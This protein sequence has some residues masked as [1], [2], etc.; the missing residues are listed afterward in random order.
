M[1]PAG[2]IQ[3]IFFDSTSNIQFVIDNIDLKIHDF[4][5]NVLTG[6]PSHY[7][8][9][10]N[11][12]KSNGVYWTLWDLI[13]ADEIHAPLVNCRSTCECEDQSSFTVSLQQ[14]ICQLYQYKSNCIEYLKFE[15]LI[16]NDAELNKLK[17]VT[18]PRIIYDVRSDEVWVFNCGEWMIDPCKSVCLLEKNKIYF[19]VSTRKLFYIACDCSVYCLMDLPFNEDPC[20][21]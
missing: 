19:N 11:Y 7:N 3:Q 16:N 1:W 8:K 13:S 12:L 18:T 9:S 10:N 2:D 20:A 4:K 15:Y 17:S 14:S 6:T 21:V 5:F